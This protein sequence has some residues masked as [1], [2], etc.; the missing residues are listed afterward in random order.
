MRKL[1]LF[2]VAAS[3]VTGCATTKPGE[4]VGL[5]RHHAE[6]KKLALAVEMLSRGDSSGAAKQLNALCTG[7]AVPGVT[8]EALFRLALLSI[9]PSAERPASGHGYQLLKRLKKEYPAS[10]WTVQATPVL[11]LINASEEIRRQ[12]RSM[13]AT[14]QSLTKEVNELNKTLEQLKHLDLE[15]EQ[16]TR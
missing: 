3:L 10:P 15:L 14:N 5:V 8:D 6:S 7:S 4:S 12:N 16:K 1:M 13:K 2:L 11:E 9:R